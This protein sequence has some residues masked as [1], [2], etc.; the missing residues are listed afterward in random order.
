MDLSNDGTYPV[1]A[2]GTLF[3]RGV[4]KTVTEK[5]NLEIKGKTIHLDGN[6][7]VAISDYNISIPKLLFQNIADSIKVDMK[8]DYIPYQK[9]D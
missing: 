4:D 8:V 6:M 2:I 9:K 1:T 5:A 3:I 7:Q